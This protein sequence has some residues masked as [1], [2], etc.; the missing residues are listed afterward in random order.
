MAI[1]LTALI[2]VLVAILLAES[3]VRQTA[4]RFFVPEIGSRLD[5]SLGLYQELAR[6][7]KASMRNAASAISESA[8]LRKA[9]TDKDA[10]ATQ[11]ELER[12]FP[13]YPSLVS[14]EVLDATGKRLAMVDRGY[15]LDEKKENKLEVVRPLAEREPDATTGDE[16]FEPET[17]GEE[18]EQAPPVPRVVAV[19]A[20]DKARFEELGEMSQFV[21]TYKQVE[22][23]RESDEQSYVYA[24]AALLGITIVAAVG[25]GTL[26]ARGVSSRLGELADA[27]KRVGAGDLSIRVPEDGA[28]EIADLAGA[29][30]R[31]LGEVE[32]SR[33]RIEYLQRI[34]AWQ[35]MARRLAHEIKN[36]LTP[37]QLAVQEVHRR[38]GGEDD[39]FRRLLDTTL[40][41]VED[42]VGTLRR[43]VSEFSSFARLP[44]AELEREDL[45]DFLRDQRE[46]IS[47]LDEETESGELPRAVLPRGVELSFELLEDA[48]PVYLDRQ[49]F[50]RALLNL[51]RNAG[52][53][54][55]G[56][57]R[58]SGR[59][60]V[61]LERDGDYLVL[62]VDD[63]GP[64]IPEEMRH[65][66]FD[67]YVTTKTD[68]TGL[69]LAIVKKIVVEHGGSIA[70]SESS[71]KG[72]RIRVRLPEADS[73]AAQAMLEAREWQ[74]PPSSTRASRS[75]EDSP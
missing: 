22:R 52:Q 17:D 28:D 35:E 49:M 42:E 34:G 31:M 30:N 63:D 43:L 9:A 45:A 29:F 11:R 19:F 37:I 44:Q 8:A 51:V 15:P 12:V 61:T 32:A 1:V 10:A 23:R 55:A 46:R 56:T 25:V 7:V 70:A 68:G 57:G 66:I 50:R 64:G 54:I 16:A 21:D 74:G 3:M 38:Y 69:G 62:D 67:P 27:T 71:L 40:E 53:A 48:A 36:P 33:A 75:S 58:E 47:L 60:R 65:T 72:A 2:P 20:A 6:A 18:E 5:Q 4:A 59:V 39:K 41:I 14:L 73:A 24:F 13:R 26:L